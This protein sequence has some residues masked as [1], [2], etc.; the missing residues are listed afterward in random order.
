MKKIWFF[1]ALTFL[2][3]PAFCE[4]MHMKDLRVAVLDVVSRVQGETIDTATLTE[5]LQVALVDRNEFRI[6]ERSLLDKIVK[7]QEFQVSGLTEGQAAKIGELVGANKVMVVSISKFTDKYLVIVKGIDAKT[8]IVDL[9][10]QVL[11]YTIGGFLDVFPVLADRLVRKARGETVAAYQIPAN[12]TP[13][14]ATAASPAVNTSGIGGTYTATGT[15]PDGS[16][17]RGSCV[18]ALRPDGSYSFSW[19]IGESTSAG[20]GTL[21]KGVLTVDW[22][23]DSPVIY[24]VQKDGTTLVGT[25]AD[26]DATEKLTR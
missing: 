24:Q 9:S 20:V 12:P 17:Y 18:V 2:A 8:G 11:S 5:M 16:A 22:G 19:A 26:G 6:V 25:W 10:D 7:E 21:E 14:T 23:D 15:N 4:W 1:V 3:G 13:Q